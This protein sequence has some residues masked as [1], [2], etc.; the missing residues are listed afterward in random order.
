MSI[1]GYLKNLTKRTYFPSVSK[2]HVAAPYKQ[3]GVDSK[4]GT[5][6]GL[7][8]LPVSYV[9][10]FLGTGAGYYKVQSAPG[11]YTCGYA[12]SPP[13]GAVAGPFASSGECSDAVVDDTTSVFPVRVHRAITT[14]VVEFVNSRHGHLPEVYETSPGVYEYED[15]KFLVMGSSRVMT[16]P[17][18]GAFE[19]HGATFAT[20]GQTTIVYTDNEHYAEKSDRILQASYDATPCADVP[21]VKDYPRRNV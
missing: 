7:L 18:F 8:A 1:L 17:Q 5:I 4:Y 6:S 15:R 2:Q 3:S 19:S 12:S 16:S 20:A 13:A 21:K 10:N 9:E 11:V 14:K